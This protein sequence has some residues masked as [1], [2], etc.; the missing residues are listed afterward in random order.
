MRSIESKGNWITGHQTRKL[1]HGY[2]I[3]ST[4]YDSV[5]QNWTAKSHASLIRHSAKTT[6]QLNSSHA[7]GLTYN[8]DI[9]KHR[10]MIFPSF[11]LHKKTEITTPSTSF[12]FFWSVVTNPSSI[13]WNETIPI[14]QQLATIKSSKNL[15][16][17]K[18]RPDSIKTLFVKANQESISII[19]ISHGFFWRG[20]TKKY[21]SVSTGL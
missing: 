20:G 16:F 4:L 15:H 21:V 8:S 3:C 5:L 2:I 11:N 6:K 9:Y 7:S 19:K 14:D 17:S 10:F 18:K 1:F 13:F 12:L